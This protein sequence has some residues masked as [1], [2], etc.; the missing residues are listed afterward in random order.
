MSIET[1]RENK[2]RSISKL[3]HF[4]TPSIADIFFIT[5]FLSLALGSTE[6]LLGDCD[7]GYHIRAGEYIIQ[8]LSIPRKDIFSFISPPINWTAHEWLSEVIMAAIHSRFGLK[9]VAVFYSGLIALVYYLLSRILRRLNINFFISSI[10]VILTLSS[11]LLHLFARP[12][13]FSWVMVVVWYGF[14]DTYRHQGKN[15]L[16]LLPILMVLWVNLH[17]GFIIGFILLVIYGAGNFA[18]SLSGEKAE[19]EDARHKG[20]LIL[21]IS[22]VCLAASLLNP[23]G[24]HIL[25]FPLEFVSNRYLMDH[26]SEFLAPNFHEFETLP[27]RLLLLSIIALIAVSRKRLNIIEF[28]LLIFFIN[29][30]LYSVRYIPLFAII[31]APIG[32]RLA[33]QLLNASNTGIIIWLRRKG[34]A[35]AAIDNQAKGYFWPSLCV[36]TLTSV[37]AATDGTKVTFNEKT[38]PVAAVAFMQQEH[39]PGNMFNN[40]EFGDYIIY[41]DWPQYRVFIDG[42]AD[43]YGGERVKEYEKIS[44]FEP[45][46]ESVVKKYNMNWIIFDADSV[47]SR[48]LYGRNDWRLIYADEVA[49]IFVHN[50]PAYERLIKKYPNVKPTHR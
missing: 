37:M 25:F 8:T 47:L 17:G 46:W 5:I 1:A 34:T 26:I 2:I 21:K 6:K 12:H 22:L 50:I 18:M 23:I 38:K 36:I 19:R 3:S 11:S 44:R 31:V 35:F 41:A 39:I 45:G 14:L 28:V 20:R 30:G 43:M 27:F 7:T 29:M 13:I 42:R 48:Y 32:A 10:L 15:L 33:N 24:Y 16:Y 40:D 4:L 9:G 49:N